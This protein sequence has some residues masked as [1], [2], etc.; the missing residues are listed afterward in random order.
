M[1]ENNGNSSPSNSAVKPRPTVL[2]SSDGANHDQLLA[3]SDLLPS[4]DA[5]SSENVKLAGDDAPTVAA[6]LKELPTLVVPPLTAEQAGELEEVQDR[7]ETLDKSIADI[8]RE[9]DYHTT[10]TY[11]LETE[12]LN[13]GS[14]SAEAGGSPASSMTSPKAVSE[15]NDHD[16]LEKKRSL[17]NRVAILAVSVAI[18]ALFIVA[19]WNGAGFV[20]RFLKQD[21]YLT[22]ILICGPLACLGFAAKWYAFNPNRTAAFRKKVEDYIGII[23][24]IGALLYFLSF[25]LTFGAGGHHQRRTTQSASAHS[26]QSPARPATTANTAASQDAYMACLIVG[27]LISENLLTFVLAA[28]FIA[29]LGWPQNPRR[30][31]LRQN[32]EQLRQNGR[33]FRDQRSTL[34]RRKAALVE[35]K[36]QSAARNASLL[37]ILA[38]LGHMLIFAAFA[39]CYPVR[40][41]E[42][43]QPAKSIWTI[44]A[45]D[46][47]EEAMQG[48]YN[49]LLDVINRAPSGMQFHILDGT[50]V[51]G[52]VDFEIPPIKN[53]EGRQDALMEE[54]DVLRAWMQNSAQRGETAAFLNVPGV[55]RQIS[56]DL[57]PGDILILAGSDLYENREDAQWA[58]F[59]HSQASEPGLRYRVPSD[60]TF[61]VTTDIHPLGTVHLEERLRGVSIFWVSGGDI[62]GSE[63]FR[64]KLE[65]AWGLYLARQGAELAIVSPDATR[66]LGRVFQPHFKPLS[67]S[68]DTAQTQ[69][70]MLSFIRDGAGFRV[71]TNR[72]PAH[73]SFPV[74]APPA[75]P[76]AAAS[77]PQTEADVRANV[78]RTALALNGQWTFGAMWNGID[79]DIDVHGIFSDGEN[80]YFGRTNSVHGRYIRD[81]T[82]ATGLD[83]EQIVLNQVP[84]KGQLRILLNV[85]RVRGKV[86]SPIT[87][88]FVV[89]S[90]N[91]PML[92]GTWRIN[93]S[94]GDKG[95]SAPGSSKYWVEINLDS[96]KP[97]RN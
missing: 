79:A 91:G 64:D 19:V 26:W 78:E 25:A 85:Y 49:G 87:G 58:S 36:R 7:I 46:Q 1:S 47:G 65:R 6:L 95:E 52:L 53:S 42:P 29:L 20:K 38:R 14:S 73:I 51:R 69:I 24:I 59:F 83:Y 74:I 70:E 5:S 39:H 76:P 94:E 57:K 60:A 75:P 17:G 92:E 16:I 18:L 34:K 31:A 67:F 23:G 82:S 55:L 56:R 8:D 44:I 86:T 12:R 84:A 62:G 90:G 3:S 11:P 93:A 68:L 54:L 33:A 72:P 28:H 97:I 15:R 88:K 32:L 41:A 71:V 89:K 40:A 4:P 30:I 80:L 48:L 50:R 77:P 45:P 13:S 37:K 2:L 43:I 9:I 10:H 35:Q 22:G 27:Q 61:L 81:H 96:A 21:T 63:L 66:V